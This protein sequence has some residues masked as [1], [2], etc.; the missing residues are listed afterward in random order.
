MSIEVF[1]SPSLQVLINDVAMVNTTG[2]TSGECLQNLMQRFPQLKA[3]LLDAN[4]V[5]QPDYM[6][7]VNGEN[8]YPEELTKPVKEG[9][10]IHVMSFFV[11]G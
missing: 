10:K 6:I 3:V 11:G 2:K 8:A 7:Y 9:D 5:L 1:L 4:Q